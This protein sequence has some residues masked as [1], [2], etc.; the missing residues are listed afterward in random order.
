MIFDDWAGV[1]RV[2]LV[3]AAAYLVLVLILRVCGKRTLS[4]MN[5]FDLVV[6]IALGST[7][8]TVLLSKDVAL[9][10]GI[11]AFVLLALLQMLVASL[12]QRSERFQRLIKAEPAL[13]L[14]D[15]KPVRAALLR[16]RVTE[17]ELA[18]AVRAAGH[19]GFGQVAAVVL[20][21]DGSFSVIGQI[22]IDRTAMS[23]V[24]WPD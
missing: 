21:T 2:V 10:E 13:L 16:E 12:A 20:E 8:A 23:Q 11:V 1:L 7:L 9:V 14:S 4:K 5:A 3:G 22:G 18:A 15:G 24:R 19:A 6:T 17:E